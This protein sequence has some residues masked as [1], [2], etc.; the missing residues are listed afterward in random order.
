MKLNVK[1]KLLL[2]GLVQHSISFRTELLLLCV[3]KKGD[4]S[5]SCFF[6]VLVIFI[7]SLMIF[8]AFVMLCN[9]FVFPLLQ[10]ILFPLF[11]L[12]WL[13]LISMMHPNKKYEEVPDVELS[14]LDASILTN[15]VLGFTP[16]TNIT[17]SIVQKASVDHL[18]DGTVSW[19]GSCL[20]Q[21]PL[22]CCAVCFIE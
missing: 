17:R 10:E 4:P 21:Q 15:V 12:F 19:R 6:L 5:S 7:E 8:A 2:L 3:L 9:H 11:F 14:A 1:E 16:V 22:L 13:I 20:L 18:H